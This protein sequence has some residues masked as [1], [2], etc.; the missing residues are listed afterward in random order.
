M[1]DEKCGA[2]TNDGGVCDFAGTYPDGKCGHHTEHDQPYEERDSK[3]TK[4]R[5]EKIASAIEKGKSLNSAARMAGVTP[6]T[7]YNWLDK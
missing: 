7:V 3:L 5:Q 1:T 4:E 6:Q 2:E